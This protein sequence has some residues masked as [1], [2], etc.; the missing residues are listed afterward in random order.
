MRDPGVGALT[1]AGSGGEL[2]SSATLG[3]K[4]SRGAELLPFG[5]LSAFVLHPAEVVVL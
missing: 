1:T 2:G 3:G 5:Y 4:E